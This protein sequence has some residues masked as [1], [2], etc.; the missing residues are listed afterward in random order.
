M[1][2][3]VMIPEMWPFFVSAKPFGPLTPEMSV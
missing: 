3:S 2:S 1:A